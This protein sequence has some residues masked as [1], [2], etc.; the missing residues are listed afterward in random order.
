MSPI[1]NA[2]LLEHSQQRPESDIALTGCYPFNRP[3]EPLMLWNGQARL[4]SSRGMTQ[5]LDV[6][7]ELAWT[8]SSR[9]GSMCLRSQAR[10]N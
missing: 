7:V 9:T 6:R 5:P 8:G 3:D 4:E 1:P 10:P 2:H